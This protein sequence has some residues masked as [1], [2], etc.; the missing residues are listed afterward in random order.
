[1]DD[2]T[3]DLEQQLRE[4]PFDDGIDPTHKQLLERKLL[5]NFNAA[6]ARHTNKWRFV[7]ISGKSDSYA[8]AAAVLIGAFIGLQFLGGTSGSVWCRSVTKWL[9]RK[10]SSTRPQ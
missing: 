1:M 5:L 6:Q 3:K 4:I 8:A 2:N 9:R 10:R 7:M